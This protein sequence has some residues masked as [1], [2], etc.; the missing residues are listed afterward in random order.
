[1]KRIA[2]MFGMLFVLQGVHAAESQLQLPAGAHYKSESHKKFLEFLHAITPQFNSFGR[3]EKFAFKGETKQIRAYFGNVRI[4]KSLGEEVTLDSFAMYV[5][6]ILRLTYPD[7][8]SNVRRNLGI[9]RGVPLDPNQQ[10][11]LVEFLWD[12]TE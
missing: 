11:N 12:V 1:M 5:R 7:A 4:E 10:V 9:K 3:V 8:L 2:L 6:S